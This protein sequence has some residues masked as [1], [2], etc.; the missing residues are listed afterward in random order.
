MNAPNRY[1]LFVLDEGEKLV[2]ITE[3]TKIPNAT[4][5]KIVK[6]DHTLG[7]LLRAE[8]LKDSR[9]LFAGYKVPHPLH[10][11]FLLKVQSDGSVTASKLVTDACQSLLEKLASVEA[12]FK[13]EFTFMDVDGPA[14]D[15]GPYG[16]VDPAQWEGGKDY[17]DL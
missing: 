3:D 14:K 11:Y 12:K 5:F 16:T 1:E 17:L 9:C 6:E 7:N 8:L 15:V 4:T 10:P 2:E 13:R